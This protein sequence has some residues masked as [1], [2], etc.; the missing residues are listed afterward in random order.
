MSWIALRAMAVSA[1]AAVLAVA[2]WLTTMSTSDAAVLSAALEKVE[3]ADTLH[4]QYTQGDKSE[5][6]WVGREG[7]LRWD[8]ADGT[9][10]IAR[11]GKTWLIDERANRVT[12]DRSWGFKGKLD[13]LALLGLPE[14]GIREAVTAAKSVGECACGGRTCERY[15]VDIPAEQG[16]IRLEATV[17]KATGMLHS[18][19]AKGDRNGR[20]EGMGTLTVLGADEPVPDGMFVVADTLTE[21]GR[22]GKV[23]DVQGVVSVKP[24]MHERWTPVDGPMLLKPGDWVRTD[25]RGANAVAIRLVPNTELVLGPGSLVEIRTPTQIRLFE[26]EVKAVV[27][28]GA[29]KEARA[30]EVQVG[31]NGDDK[32][33]RVIGTQILRL[34]D[35]QLTRLE[36]APLWLQGFEGVTTKESLGSLVALVDGRDVPL[37]VGYHKVSVDIRDQIARTVIEESFVNHTAATLEG[38]FY[39]PL[40]A[41]ASI[42]GFGMWIGDRLVEADI[43]EKQRAREIYETIL[44]ER[45]DP[46]LLEWQGGNLFKARVFPIPGHA[47]KRIKISYTQVLPLE[48]NSYRYSYALQSEL[49]RQHPLRELSIDVKINSAVPLAGVRSPTHAVRLDKTAHSAHVEFAAQEYTPSRDFEVVVP[50]AKGQPEVVLIPHRRGDDGY[51]MLQLMPPGS[52]GAWEREVLPN[53]EPIELVVLADTSASMDGDARKRQEALVASL[54]SALSPQDRINLAVCDV[55]CRWAFEQSKAASAENIAA[56]RQLLADRASLGWTDLDRAFASVLKKAGPKTQVVYIGDGI[57]TGNDGD[58]AAAA[59]RLRRLYEGKQGTFYAVSVSSTFDA[60]V[61]KAIA[62]LGGGSVRQVSGEHGP[63]QVA[64]DLLAEMMQPALRGLSVEFRGLRTARVYPTELPNLA[65]GH[66]QIVLGRYLPEGKEQKGEVIVTG[67]RDGKPVRWAAKVALET[68]SEGNSF[69]PRLWARMHLDA[70]LEQGNA[71]AVR[72]EIIALSEEYHIL[73]PYTSL[74]I[75]ESD[76]DRERFAVKPR[77]QM[78]DGERFFAEGRANANYELLQQQMR[79]ASDWRIGLRRA[80]LQQ[81]MAMGRNPEVF[82]RY[83]GWPVS[84]GGMGLAGEYGGSIDN[85]HWWGFAGFRVNGPVTSLGVEVSA[86][87]APTRAPWA[88]TSSPKGGPRD[89]GAFDLVFGDSN[90]AL[91]AGER[92]EEDAKSERLWKEPEGRENLEQKIS[93][94]DF[95]DQDY[96]ALFDREVSNVAG[97][98]LSRLSIDGSRRRGDGV[99]VGLSAP[100]AFFHALP[101]PGQYPGW[102]NGL[103]PL[104]PGPWEEPRKQPE[105]TWPK[106]AQALSRSLL[107]TET[108]AKLSGGLRI[109]VNSALYDPRLDETTSRSDSLALMGPQEWLVRSESLG[110]QTI[111][112]WCNRQE[113][114]IVGEGFGLGRVRASSGD[115]LSGPPLGLQGYVLR[116]LEQLY[117]GCSVEVQPQGGDRTLLVMSHPSSPQVQTRVLID[118]RRAVVLQIES[119]TGDKVTATTRL[120]DFVEV[121]GAWWATRIEVSDTKGRRTSLVTQRFATRGAE[122]IGKE[123]AGQLPDR[124]KVLLLEE[125]LPTALE[126]KRAVAEGKA[127]FVDRM[128]LLAYYVERQL[129]DRVEEELAKV[130]PLAEKK[131]GFRW[132]RYT[133]LRM[134]RH[135]EEWKREVLGEAERLASKPTSGEA[136]GNDLFLANYLLGE[137][138]SVLAANEALELL[139]LLEPVYVRQPGWLHAMKQPEEARARLL[140]QTGQGPQALEV[141]RKL[142]GQYPGDVNVQTQYAQALINVGE[143]EAACDWLRKALAVPIEWQ[144]HEMQSLRNT[145]ANFLWNQARY[146]ELANVLADW[147]KGNPAEALPYQQYLTVLVR[148]GR[149]KEAFE[150]MAKWLKEGR[151]SDSLSADGAARLQAAVQLA[152]G[153]GWNMWS[154]QLD[155]RWLGPLAETALVLAKRGTPPKAAGP[156]MGP[157]AMSQ[158]SSAARPDAEWNVVSQIM[159]HHRFRQTD[160]AHRVRQA[161]AALLVE[162]MDRLSVEH[163]VRLI[164]WIREGDRGMKEIPRQKMAEGIRGRWK[165]EEDVQKRHSLGNA[166][167]QILAA[168]APEEWLGFLRER[169]QQGPKQY[170]TQYARELF[171]ALLRQSWSAEREGEV[172]G[173]IGKM[174]DDENAGRRTIGEVRELMRLDD[175][176]IQARYKALMEKVER[177][178]RLTRTELQRVQA[179][180]MGQAQEGLV[181]RLSK[182]AGRQPEK[183][184]PWIEIERLCL[185]VRLDQKLDGVA[186]ACWEFLGSKPKAV[187]GEDETERWLGQV[188]RG[189]YLMTLANVAAR[190]GAKPELAKRLL[191]YAAAGIAAEPDNAD[192]KLFEYELLV[193]M[194]RPGPLEKTLRGWIEAGDYDSRWRVALGYLLAEQGKLGPAIE[195]FEKVRAADELAPADCV[196]LSDWYL[197]VDRRE[198]RR[199]AMTAAFEMM[200]ERQLYRWLDTQLRAWQQ[201]AGQMPTEL[202]ERVPLVLVVL[203]GKSSSPGDC[204]GRLQQFYRA[205]RDFRLL[206]A[207]ADAVV[208]Q[209][210]EKVYPVLANLGGVL[211][212]VHDE[213]TVDSLVEHIGEVRQREKTPV[214]RRALDLLLVAVERRAAELENQAGPHAERALA[215]LRQATRQEWSKGE[216]RLMADFLA[217]MG[218]IAQ[219]DLADE[220]LRQL[221]VLRLQVAGGTVDRLHIAL[222]QAQ[223]IWSYDRRKEATDLLEAALNEY[224]QGAEMPAPNEIRDA[225]ETLL[226]YLE[227][228]GH[229]ARGEEVVERYLQRAANGQQRT[230]LA[231]RLRRLQYNA[232][233]NG[234]S[235]SLGS[236]QTL[237]KALERAVREEIAGG[238]VRSKGKVDAGEAG[239]RAA[240]RSGGMPDPDGVFQ[241]I[242]LLS[243]IY[244]TAAEKKLPGVVDDLKGFAFGELPKLLQPAVGQYEAI[245]RV[246]GQTLHDVVSPRDGLD[247]LV[248]RLENEPAWMHYQNQGGWGRFGDTMANWRKEAGALDAGLEERLL[249]VVLR[250]LREDLETRERRNCQIY[251]RGNQTFWSE[252]TADFARVADEV[253][254]RNKNSGST[255]LY[256]AEYLMF[257]LQHCDRAIE[258][259]LDAN[260][261]KILDERGQSQLVVFLQSQQRFGETIGIL[262]PLIEQ[263]PDNATY[264][265]WLM[266]AYFRTKQPDKLKATR[267]QADEYFH[268]DHRWTEDVLSELARGCLETELFAQAVEYYGELIPWHER[269]A[270]RRGIG[271]GKL[272]TYYGNMARAR[273]GMGQMIE[274]IDAACGAIVSWGRTQGNR[275]QATAALREVIERAPNLDK[276]V[277]L[278]DAE[279]AKTGMHRAIVR[280]V[281]G[282][283]YRH[284]DQRKAIAQ[285]KLAVALDPEDAEAERELIAAYDAAGDQEGAV[286]QLIEYAGQARRN[287]ELYRD[288]GRRYA[289]LGRGEEAERAYTSIVE[290]LPSESESH[291]MLAEVRQEENRWEEAAAEWQRVAEIRSLEPMGLLR[292]AAAQIELKQWEKAAETLRKLECQCWPPRFHDVRYQVDQLRRRLPERR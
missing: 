102:L 196:A 266:L 268:A 249:G 208:G 217:G 88:S 275:Q 61:M 12:S 63:E 95:Y 274:A 142:A 271:D 120:G 224:E 113:R 272:S 241:L 166:L 219:R 202:D 26:G 44:R 232:L 132:I 62:G 211:G 17:D 6:I 140:Q 87:A 27:G 38:V 43:V 122:E 7:R 235:V 129:W 278:L 282:E 169:L 48:G 24:V 151:Q 94:F 180:K 288:L 262:L 156:M 207:L 183:L 92:F 170:R 66:Q 205:T 9:Y 130:E 222:R 204:V 238:A 21:D 18:L 105:S 109:E 54:F 259:L 39:F 228:Q 247:F 230:W 177:P 127:T 72:D 68:S 110:S 138:N 11:D 192:W 84:G 160:V 210:A 154:N 25:M 49:L 22:V 212:E 40:P 152:L 37:T 146:V 86:E 30:L 157:N 290:V 218:R 4:L 124:S 79:R 227:G 178:D 172:F 52:D 55:D 246:V 251:W 242:D 42:S 216:P 240:Q 16:A 77:F 118:T 223:T 258:I 147:V 162:Q 174:S 5:Q 256:V 96:N 97:D 279:E 284:R 176:M 133:V 19:E 203:M 163:I 229:Y 103:F 144:A 185:L 213:A 35:G 131:P 261:R 191:D 58:A 136:K 32:P 3:K 277:A 244:R 291:A 286:R 273:A 114:G 98:R 14:D 46:G 267:Q 188:L 243:S 231:V 197:A 141:Y 123:I 51:F 199:Q 149:E 82:R 167:S 64:R 175:A 59:K 194:D 93:G 233:A 10:R 187:A 89:G 264:R 76:E 143:Y 126:A 45:R 90:G 112:Q 148:A 206:A 159:S 106:E 107:R 201:D 50:L 116:S 60:M 125:P 1:A 128:V 135:H 2:G 161:M 36:K 13:V 198:Q 168:R 287:I 150:L 65:A 73:T 99:V 250:E 225:L 173:L 57:V 283:V 101:Q 67:T 215:A 29:G 137:A 33:I 269:T 83:R 221:E 47:E 234:G 285:L 69:I 74:L 255:V 80:V 252:K 248:G 237:Y 179:E 119:R 214:D 31:K 195:L 236:G 254:E 28:K 270:P 117:R 41:D 239:G 200:N 226:M 276:L 171:E 100:A 20:R 164:G 91:Q 292:L 280:R 115:D 209:T 15:V 289:R 181:E 23:T 253:A 78:R 245:V 263:H 182:E 190:R 193:A 111:V 121:G 34:R 53:G 145:Y 75:L 139:K 134:S 104:L 71:P 8:L 257:G 281:L 260:G 189:R 220:Q 85:R 155:P 81:L 186:A 108:L 153:Q 184:R 165:A 158:A 70:L 265:V 56:A